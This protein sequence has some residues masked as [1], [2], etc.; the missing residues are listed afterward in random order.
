MHPCLLVTYE[1]HPKC[2]SRECQVN[3]IPILRKPEDLLK[4]RYTEKLPSKDPH[5]TTVDVLI[6]GKVSKIRDK[7]L[8]WLKGN[9]LYVQVINYFNQENALLYHL[10]N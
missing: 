8:K 6:E 1:E 10:C 3:G 7:W 2:S 4:R 9:Y 5:L